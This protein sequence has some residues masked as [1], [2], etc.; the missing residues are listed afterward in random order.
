[1]SSHLFESPTLLNNLM[2]PGSLEPPG[3]FMPLGTQVTW[4]L[5]V[6]LGNFLAEIMYFRKNWLSFCPGFKVSLAPK[7]NTTPNAFLKHW[8]MGGSKRHWQGR[9]K[10]FFPI[11]SLRLGLGGSA[12][13]PGRVWRGQHRRGQGQLLRIQAMGPRGSPSVQP[14]GWAFKEL[15]FWPDFIIKLIPGGSIR[16]DAQGSEPGTFRICSRFCKY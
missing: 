5:L 6:G 2:L 11:L 1:M 4:G 12:P 9:R 10:S 8:N 13:G 14:Y 3:P 16:T 7:G 15:E